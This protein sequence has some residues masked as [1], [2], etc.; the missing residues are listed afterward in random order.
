MKVYKVTSASNLLEVLEPE[1]EGLAVVGRCSSNSH[2]PLDLHLCDQKQPSAIGAQTLSV[3]GVGFSLSATLRTVCVQGAADAQLGGGGRG[4]CVL[5]PETPRSS[6]ATSPALPGKRQAF[7]RPQGSGTA[8]AGRLCP[9]G[10]GP[11][12]RRL[13]LPTPWPPRTLPVWTPSSVTC[14]S[15][16]LSASSLRTSTWW[17]PEALATKTW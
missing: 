12:E 17:A 3:W 15:P 6:A 9:W 8:P 14:F 5:R 4:L 11:R 13:P 1:G 7:S 2:P 10:G 16:L